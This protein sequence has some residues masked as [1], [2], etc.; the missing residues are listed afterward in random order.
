MCLR[1]FLL[2]YPA[3]IY[4]SILNITKFINKKTG[5]AFGT[6]GCAINDKTTI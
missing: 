3:L 2:H 5:K 1:N 6:I 4:N